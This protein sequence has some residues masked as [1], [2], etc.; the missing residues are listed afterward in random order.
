MNLELNQEQLCELSEEECTAVVGGR[1]KHPFQ[2]IAIGKLLMTPDGDP[3]TVYVDG[4]RV[5]SMTTGFVHL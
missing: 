5:N 2:H 3:V 4:V 1:M